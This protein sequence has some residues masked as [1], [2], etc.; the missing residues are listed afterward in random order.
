M[1]SE[2]VYPIFDETCINTDI[3][4]L[5][6]IFGT[7]ND[8]IHNSTADVIELED[9]FE[10]FDEVFVDNSVFKPKNILEMHIDSSI[11][12]SECTFNTFSEACTTIEK[13]AAQTNA[14]II[15]DKTTRNSDKSNY[16]QAL[17]VCK[18]QGKY[19]G[20]NEEYT[21]KRIGCSFAIAI[22][23]QKRSQKFAITKS[24]LEYNYELCLNATKFSTVARKFDKDNLG[25][26]EKLHDDGL[27]TKD[28]FSVRNSVSCKYIHKPNIYNAISHHRQHKLHGLNE[29]EMLFKTLY[30]DENILGYIALKAAYSTEHDQDGEF[31]QGIF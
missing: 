14:I 18:K 9:T 7:F 31:V 26:I 29:I 28:I 17:F 22:N 1:E 21:T 11:V 5:D 23:Y 15:L 4:E 24:I 3:M 6:Y 13:Y 25:L 19:S 8:H 12:V 16:R 30:D 27:R 20:V 2:F 10:T